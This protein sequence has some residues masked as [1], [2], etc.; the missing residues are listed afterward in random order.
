MRAYSSSEIPDPVSRTAMRVKSAVAA[1]FH[2]DRAAPRRELD[3]VRQQVQ[4]H[5]LKAIGIRQ[6]TKI[7]IAT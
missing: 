6:Q 3:R 7:I 5:L 2:G 4:Q 1:A